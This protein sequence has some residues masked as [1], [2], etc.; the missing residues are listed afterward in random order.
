VTLND[1]EER[2]PRSQKLLGEQPF[3]RNNLL[4]LYGFATHS[5]TG[6][7]LHDMDATNG[8]TSGDCLPRGVEGKK[9]KGRPGLTFSPDAL[10]EGL[11]PQRSVHEKKGRS[12]RDRII[13]ENTCEKVRTRMEPRQ[14]GGSDWRGAPSLKNHA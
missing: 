10:Q 2:H 11:Q 5:L 8:G 13:I 12:R 14:G 3:D 4:G 7:T 6:K 9:E 1:Y